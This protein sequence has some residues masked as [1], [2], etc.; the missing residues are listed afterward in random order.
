MRRYICNH[1]KCKWINWKCK[2]TLNKIFVISYE[3]L[4]IM[5]QLIANEIILSWL[6]SHYAVWCSLYSASQPWKRTWDCQLYFFLLVKFVS[7]TRKCNLVF[8][9]YTEIST[10]SVENY[11]WDQRTN[12]T[13]CG[14]D[15]TN[16]NYNKMRQTI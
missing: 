5:A 10:D 15:I 6:K 13:A 16:T 7:S 1:I 9:G 14:T 11:L 12:N 8:P 4:Y 2:N 3:S